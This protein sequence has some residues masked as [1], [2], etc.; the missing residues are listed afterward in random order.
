[1][2]P[3]PHRTV[4]SEAS[5]VPLTQLCGG[6]CEFTLTILTRLVACTSKSPRRHLVCGMPPLGYIVIRVKL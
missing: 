3:A 6:H 5:E 2:F 1:M 4:A